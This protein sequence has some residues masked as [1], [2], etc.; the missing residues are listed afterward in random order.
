MAGAVG[1]VAG[2]GGLLSGIIV[3]RKKKN[4]NGEKKDSNEEVVNIENIAESQKGISEEG[5]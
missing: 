5:L 1:G 3:Y 4:S 2:V